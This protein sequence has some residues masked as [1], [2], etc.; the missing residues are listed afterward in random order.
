MR[1][2]IGRLTRVKKLLLVAVT[3]L[4][5]ALLAQ[6]PPEQSDPIRVDVNLVNLR[7]TVRN[8][9]GRFLNT[10]SRDDIRVYENGERQDVAFFER[11]RFDSRIDQPLWLAFLIDVSG[12]TFSTRSEEILA[13]R[14]FLE[15]VNDVTQVG[16]YGFTDQLLPFQEF[17]SDRQAALAAFSSAHQ[18]RGKTAIYSSLDTLVNLMLQRAGTEDRKVVIL[19]SDGI[20]EAHQKSSVS[21]TRARMGGIVIYTVWVPSAASLYINTAGDEEKA[22]NFDIEKKEQEQAFQ[23]L[24]QATGGRHYGGFETILDFEEVM[25][26]INDEIL[27]NLYSVAYYTK[28][29]YLSRA[30]RRIEVRTSESGAKV[31]GIFKE[32]PEQIQAKKTYIEALFDQNAIQ[33]LTR[34]SRPLREIGVQLDLLRQRNMQSNLPFRLKISSASLSPDATGG[35]SAQFGVIGLLMDM[36]GN[37]VSRVREIFRANLSSKD[38]REF[39]GVIYTN[40]LSA[41]P[42]DYIFKLALLQIPSWKVTVLERAVKIQ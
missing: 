30:E 32:I 38:L 10:L 9:Q 41:P 1:K 14:T 39:R 15:N 35:A 13:A 31:L 40:R 34:D 18:H 19:I 26:N 29:P 21:I 37:E 12:S 33:S 23:R 28:D 24:S 42:G 20:D 27:G 2:R 8:Q 6:E 16:I 11:P 7:F 22:K 17:T 5:S 4:S 3:C 36:S 25:A